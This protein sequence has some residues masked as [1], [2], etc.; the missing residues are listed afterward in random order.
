MHA[1]KSRVLPL[2]DVIVGGY[3]VLVLVTV[4]T[5]TTFPLL[6][7]WSDRLP[8]TTYIQL[9]GQSMAREARVPL[10]IAADNVHP[11][12]RPGPDTNFI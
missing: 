3:I 1:V 10:P 11:A 5:R 2:G 8:Q 6:T 9:F 4:R 12:L 7:S